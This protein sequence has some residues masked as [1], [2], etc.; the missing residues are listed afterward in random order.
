LI[1]HMSL[2]VR[3]PETVAAVLAEMTGARAIRAPAP[4]FPFGS[5]FVVAGDN[6]GTSLEILPSTAVFDPRSPLGLRHRA[7]EPACSG[8]H[9]LI[10]SVCTAEQIFTLAGKQGWPA[11]E[12][13]TGMFRIVKLW[14][15]E[16]VL[17]E[18][19]PAGESER[20]VENFGASGLASLDTK[21]RQLE[22]DL[23]DGLARKFSPSVIT[24]ALGAPAGG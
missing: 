9:V 14:I 10:D 18:V 23:S 8:A 16:Y 1:R 2:G 17:V 6:R 22:T 7:S 3:N 13:E 20:Y 11:Q 4:P 5:W 21:L 24:D 19:L 15:D 12:V